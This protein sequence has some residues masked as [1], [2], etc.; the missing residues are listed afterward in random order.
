MMNNIKSFFEHILSKDTPLSDTLSE[1][2]ELL[3]LGNMYKVH[4]RVNNIPTLLILKYVKNVDDIYYFSIESNN[5]ELDLKEGEIISMTGE[6]VSKYLK[7][8]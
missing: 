8:I 5:R 7:S 3:E 6:E 2:P 1:V 4:R